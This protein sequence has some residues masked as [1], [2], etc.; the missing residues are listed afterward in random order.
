MTFEP[1]TPPILVRGGSVIWARA[2]WPIFVVWMSNVDH[3]NHLPPFSEKKKKSFPPT[4]PLVWVVQ[5]KLKIF[6]LEGKNNQV[7]CS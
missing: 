5:V 6:P 3:G 2:C 1:H 7:T 4:I